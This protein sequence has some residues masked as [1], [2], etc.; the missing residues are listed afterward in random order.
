MRTWLVAALLLCVADATRAEE[1]TA[2]VL[3]VI[4]GDTVLALLSCPA[5]ALPA[6][7]GKRPVK[8]RLAEI[9]APEKDQLGGAASSRSLAGLVLGKRVTV[10]VEAVDKYGRPVAHLV[11]GATR[12]NEEQ[13]RR[14]MAWEYSNYHGN[15]A[16]IA[17]QNEARQAGRGLW[18]QPD[19][20][21]PWRWR[22]LHQADAISPPHAAA[23]PACGSKRYCAQ[24][25]SCAEARFY[26]T[27]C[28][29]ATLD[30]NGDGVPC[31]SLCGAGS[32]ADAAR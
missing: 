20:V 9:D 4:D 16:Y 11:L 6:C 5:S 2:K 26:L 12:I 21:P 18:A 32:R 24:M 8:L 17:L 14:G 19:P 7:A 3:A 25:S 15:Q 31:E 28:G 29:V 22:K 30:G 27:R 23:D 1:I 10:Q 13:V